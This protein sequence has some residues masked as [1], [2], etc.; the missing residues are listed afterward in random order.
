LLDT[1]FTTTKGNDIVDFS[2][3][4]IFYF[5]REKS[6][7]KNILVLSNGNTNINY[8]FYSKYHDLPLGCY[9][10]LGNFENKNGNVNCDYRSIYVSNEMHAFDYPFCGQEDSPCKTLNFAVDLSCTLE[11]FSEGNNI[12]HIIHN[13]FVENKWNKKFFFF[14][15]SLHIY[16]S[17]SLITYVEWVLL[18][19]LF[20][21]LIY[22]FLEF[23]ILKIIFL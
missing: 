22:L 19:Y 10:D 17:F 2:I 11:K 6:F 13:I 23:Q 3:N 1:S 9:L 16:F 20:P 7:V 21:I 18:L 14:Y 8:N 5:S 4:N 12:D 15:I